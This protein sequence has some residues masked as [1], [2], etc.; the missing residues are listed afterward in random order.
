MHSSIVSLITGAGSGLGRCIAKEFARQGA[1]VGVSDFNFESASTVATEISQAGGKAIPIA[2]DVTSESAVIAAFEALSSASGSH[3]NSLINN[4]GHQHITP[5]I[6]CDLAQW[7]KML[8]VHLDGPFLTTRTMLQQYRARGVKGGSIVFIGSVH[9][10]EASVEKSPYVTAKHGVLGLCRATAKEAAVFGI[11]SNTVCPGFVKTPLVE[12]QIPQLA[13]KFGM[14]NEEVV[15]NVML[16]N[17]V[18][19]EWT[20]EEDIARTCAFLTFSPTNA[21]TG[22]SLIVSH[23]WHME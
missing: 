21:I 10:K 14:S 1:F 23:G 5:L 7:R 20:T 19:H 18:D 12:A 11:S 3:V 9:S 4:A 2:L 22:Q 6:D 15:K 8:A 13:A 17:T 16:R